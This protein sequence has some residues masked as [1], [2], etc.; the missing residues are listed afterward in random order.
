MCE[1]SREEFEALKKRIDDLHPTVD[2]HGHLLVDQQKQIEEVRRG[3]LVLTASVEDVR[4]DVGALASSVNAVRTEVRALASN[5]GRLADEI[6][7]VAV[8]LPRVE[9]NVARLVEILDQRKV[10]VDGTPT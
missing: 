1:V 6:T 10:I 4:V 5:V 7:P 2:E 3:M 8:T 9:R